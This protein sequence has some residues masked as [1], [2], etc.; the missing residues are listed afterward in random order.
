L[1]KLKDNIIDLN[2][3]QEEMQKN[4][5]LNNARD[6]STIEMDILYHTQQNNKNYIEIGKLLI[7]AKGRLEHGQWIK[8]LKN[9][10]EMSLTKAE[11]LMRIAEEFTNSSP[12]ANLGYTKA[13]LLIRLPAEVQDNLINEV[14][15]VKGE[16][17][18]IE[19]MSKRELEN[20]IR[21]R[22]QKNKS[23][24]VGKNFDNNDYF[25]TEIEKIRIY[26]DVLVKFI[27]TQVKDKKAQY[28]YSI[29][30]R[31]LCNETVEYINS[32]IE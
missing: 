31:H 19:E 21:E 20:V 8:W 22:K 5:A 29:E 27:A 28:D 14:H 11:N 16:L 15:K 10:I 9:N 7:E 6:I 17:K 1:K 2:S 4:A 3:K 24:K 26:M 18:S 30:L 13:S 12:V 23:S 32:F 25:Y